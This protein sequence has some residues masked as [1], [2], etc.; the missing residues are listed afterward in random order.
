MLDLYKHRRVEFVVA[1]A[2]AIVVVLFGVE[3]G[4]VT[5]IMLSIIAHLRHSY[6]PLNLLIVPKNE[7]CM[8]TAPYQQINML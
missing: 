6:K 2:T 3:V 1:V 7:C 4:I 5:A 8:K